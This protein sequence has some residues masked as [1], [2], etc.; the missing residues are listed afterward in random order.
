MKNTDVELLL[1]RRGRKWCIIIE[2]SFTLDL[3]NEIWTN[4]INWTVSQLEH[5]KDVSRTSYHM[6][7]FNTKQ[8]A[9]KF[10]TLFWLKWGQ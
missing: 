10:Q 7:Y 1:Q 4:A 3:H 8:E 6:W 2:E 9:E 5:R